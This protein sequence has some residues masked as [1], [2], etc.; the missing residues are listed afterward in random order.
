MKMLI[1]GA[2]GS[3]KGTQADALTGILGVPA[4]STGAMLRSA[5][6]AQTETGKKAQQYIAEGKLVPDDVMIDLVLDRLNEKDCEG[7][8]MLDGFPRTLAQAE[9]MDKAGIEVDLVVVMEASEETIMR[10]LSGRRI[11]SC[12]ATYHTFFKPSSKGEFC[13]VCGK[14]LEIRE[15]DKPETIKKRLKIYYSQTAPVVEYY[16][17]KGILITVE[18]ERGVDEVTREVLKALGRG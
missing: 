2:P 8:Y 3:G 12:G 18:S 11:C 5:I 15:D 7:G 1:M 6:A 10:R 17:K 9:A 4:I 14:R 16:R 13:E